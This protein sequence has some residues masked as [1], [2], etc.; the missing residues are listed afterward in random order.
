MVKSCQLVPNAGYV[1]LARSC[2]PSDLA[3]EQP[4]W[5]T[6]GILRTGCVQHKIRVEGTADGDDANIEESG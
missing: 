5:M 6:P 4:C 1:I 2:H 3:S